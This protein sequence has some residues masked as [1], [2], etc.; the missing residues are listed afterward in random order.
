MSTG[1]HPY[2]VTQVPTWASLGPGE[3]GPYGPHP[4]LVILV[5]TWESPGQGESGPHL[6]LN[7]PVDFLPHLDLIAV[8]SFLASTGPSDFAPSGPHLDLVTLVPTWASSG[9]GSTA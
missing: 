2:L 3:S 4:D 9:H 6:G 5:T 1:T 8:D 7:S